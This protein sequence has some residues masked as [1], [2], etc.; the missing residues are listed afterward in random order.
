MD[1][2]KLITPEDHVHIEEIILIP[3]FI[4]FLLLSVMAII[5][6]KYQSTPNN[7]QM[8]KILFYITLQFL[9]MPLFIIFL[10][11]N[12]L[13]IGFSYYFL[14]KI[15][16]IS[17]K[18]ICSWIENCCIF[19]KKKNETVNTITV[20]KHVDI[21][22]PE[23][24]NRYKDLNNESKQK[25]DEKAKDQNLNLNNNKSLNIFNKDN[26]NTACRPRVGKKQINEGKLM[27]I[28][29]DLLVNED[30]SPGYISFLNN[31]KNK[32][33]GKFELKYSNSKINSTHTIQQNI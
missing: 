12:I 21:V 17:G 30:N 15:Y 4:F 20:T 2:T 31:L 3:I 13:I 7:K 22:F 26:H 23:R 11:I 18:K 24:A 8:M 10:M 33:K 25:E 19:V 6:Y 27:E 1:H 14:N 5:L 28:I 9:F 32:A 29:S 16:Y